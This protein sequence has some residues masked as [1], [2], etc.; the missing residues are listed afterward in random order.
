MRN[1]I[2]NITDRN[3]F[4]FVMYNRTAPKGYVKE[5]LVAPIP[6]LLWYNYRSS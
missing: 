4:T 1:Y 5:L 3:K 6:Q 2:L